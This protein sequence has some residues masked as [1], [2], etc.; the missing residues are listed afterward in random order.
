MLSSANSGGCQSPEPPERSSA[1]PSRCRDLLRL[2]DD[3]RIRH[4]SLFKIPKYLSHGHRKLPENQSPDL[5]ASSCSNL[6]TSGSQDHSWGT[7]AYPP[8]NHVRSKYGGEAA[9]HARSPLTRQDSGNMPRNLCHW[10]SLLMSPLGYN[11]PSEPPPRHVCN[12]PRFGHSGR[13]VRFRTDSSALPPGSDV[14]DSPGIRGVLS[15][16]LGE[17]HPQALPEPYVNL[18]AHTAPDVRPFPWQSCQWA[19]RPGLAR[20]SRSNQSRAPLVWRRSRLNLRRAQRM[21]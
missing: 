19:K 16:R 4:Q 13:D 3:L 15:S 12:G 1:G 9:F 14:A 5:V 17:S 11:L 8:T 18:S 10:E 6:A 2:W 7:S 21:T 20:R